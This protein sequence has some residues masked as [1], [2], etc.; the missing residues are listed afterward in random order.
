M[1]KSTA[2]KFH[3][4]SDGTS[5]TEATYS[6]CGW[7]VGC[8]GSPL[9]KP[10]ARGLRCIVRASECLSRAR[11]LREQRYL[12]QCEPSHTPFLTFALGKPHPS[13]LVS[14]RCTMKVIVPLLVLGQRAHP[15]RPASH[16][17]G[18]CWAAGEP[19][20]ASTMTP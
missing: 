17:E 9:A 13:T 1:Q 16:G 15:N 3:D 19:Q 12:S 4:V 7:K 14:G 6:L 2:W 8:G 20:R 5:S 11:G 10:T 18:F